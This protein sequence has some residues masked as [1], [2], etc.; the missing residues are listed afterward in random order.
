MLIG[1]GCVMLEPLADLFPVAVAI[2]HP[3]ASVRVTCV[4]MLAFI[5]AI[6]FGVVPPIPDVLQ[7]D[8]LI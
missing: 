8:L 5:G 4:M 7:H 6:R 1:V 3:R 2:L